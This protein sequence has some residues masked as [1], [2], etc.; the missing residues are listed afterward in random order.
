MPV[1]ITSKIEGP[2]MVTTTY[3]CNEPTT[4]SGIP[5]MTMPD[6]NYYGEHDEFLP[7]NSFFGPVD[8]FDWVS[9][10]GELVFFQCPLTSNKISIGQL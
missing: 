2:S 10:V 1:N 4:E 8:G 5:D 3:L 7:L 6:F 9:F